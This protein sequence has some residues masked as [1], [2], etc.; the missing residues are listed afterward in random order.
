MK[1]AVFTASTPDWTPEEAVAE[2]AAQGWDGVEWR[3]VDQ[4]PSQGG[5]G[6]WAGNKATWPASSFPQDASRIKELTESA[7]LEMS[8]VGAYATCDQLEAVDRLLEGAAALGV[9][10]MRVPPGK[11][12]PDGYAASF[13]RARAQYREVAA[14]A[15]KHG[16]KAMVELH[17]LSL[18][19]SASS[20]VRFL[21]GLDPAHVGVIH[22]IGNMLI[23]GYENIPW[24]LE[25]LGDYL[26][27]VHVK[28][29]VPT[30]VDDT[31]GQ[32]KWRWDWAP[33]SRG[34]GH[35]PELFDALKSIGY[36][37]WVAVEDFS[38]EAPLAERT[39]ANL[40][41]LRNLAA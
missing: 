8:A 36:D 16:V 12:G 9:T 10:K 28:N 37:G 14:L 23:E 5:G 6:F 27:H 3:V 11:P 19:S 38:T 1:F 20:A 35:L 25:I 31:D 41:Y 18:T 29:A 15:A 4:K 7:G 13:E 40:A 21:D 34:V 33:L 2:L 17:H 32:T 39:R 24:S 22:D 26:A 30:L